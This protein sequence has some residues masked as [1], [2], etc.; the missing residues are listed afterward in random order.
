MQYIE[1][2]IDYGDSIIDF[3]NKC[4]EMLEIPENVEFK[5]DCTKIEISEDRYKAFNLKYPDPIG[6]GCCG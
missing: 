2:D 6:F 1:V 3:Y 4:A 5:Y